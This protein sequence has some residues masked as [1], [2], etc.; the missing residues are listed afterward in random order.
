MLIAQ[1]SDL[2]IGPIGSSQDENYRTA[3]HLEAA[4]THLLGLPRRP[5]VVVAT[6]DLVDGGLPEEYARLRSILARLPMPVLVIPGN[7]DRRETLAAA[8][9]DQ[10][11]LPQGGGFLHYTLENW[12]VRVIALDTT[13]PG[14]ASGEMCAER[15]SWLDQR[16][17]EQ[18]D[19]PT[20][21]LMHHPPFATGIA[22]MDEMGLSGKEAFAAVLR[23][24][25]QV[26]RILCGHIHRP[27][28]ARVA[29]TVAT[30][31]PS[32][33]HQIALDLG[34]ERRLAVIMEPP[35]CM[36]HLWSPTGLVSHLSPIGHPTAPHVLFDG[37]RWLPDNKLPPG[38]HLVAHR[39]SNT[40]PACSTS[41]ND[42]SM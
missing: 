8:F 7:H 21:L 33:A 9:A 38:F 27:I 4:V 36:L 16:L 40:P 30:V 42:V 32:T 10:P 19:R 35:A 28:T 3:H 41:I 15:L 20:I 1:I 23:R 29:G 5:D 31:C 6:G 25:S 11:W 34:P 37:A 2:H 26:E 13:V 12:P 39:T 24:H 18:P 14:K 22:A 17:S